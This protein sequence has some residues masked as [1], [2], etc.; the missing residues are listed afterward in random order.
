MK[1]TN[2]Q[3]ITT[4]EVQNKKYFQQ[5][6]P[7]KSIERS[8]KLQKVGAKQSTKLLKDIVPYDNI[9]MLEEYGKFAEKASQFNDILKKI[10]SKYSRDTKKDSLDTS[11]LNENIKAF[12]D[13]YNVIKR[14]F[15][16]L[17]KLRDNVQ[18]K[19][20]GNEME[21]VGT[22]LNSKKVD[23][24]RRDR[25]EARAQK[26]ANSSSHRDAYDKFGSLYRVTNHQP[27]AN[28]KISGN[29]QR[30]MK[31]NLINYY[32]DIDQGYRNAN[33]KYTS[34]NL[35]NSGNVAKNINDVGARLSS[36]IEETRKALNNS[37]IA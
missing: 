3:V 5:S 20:N 27:N 30:A 11:I 31:G 9:E 19:I 15:D 10:S 32:K 25:A 8:Y 18:N 35:F 16:E 17:L 2:P 7:S 36:I 14:D 1:K 34:N 21:K 4:E 13:G 26:V 29:A 6:T 33:S 28:G 12:V 24:S 37:D 23:M 22:I